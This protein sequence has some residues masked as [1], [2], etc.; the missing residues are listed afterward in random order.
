MVS[1]KDRKA[2]GSD[3]PV[4]DGVVKGEKVFLSA[5]H[6]AEQAVFILPVYCRMVLTVIQFLIQ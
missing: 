5:E 6:H 1:R 3:G 4:R 2:E